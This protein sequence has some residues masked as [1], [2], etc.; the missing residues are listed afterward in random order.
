MAAAVVVVVNFFITTYTF[1]YTAFCFNKWI[2]KDD[3]QQNLFTGD[4]MKWL[5]KYI[6]QTVNFYFY[7]EFVF[8]NLTETKSI[9]FKLFRSSSSFLFF[10]LFLIFN[11]LKIKI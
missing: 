9:H 5:Y 11:V 8:K 6:L 10:Y 4:G 7:I 1:K 2:L 3:D